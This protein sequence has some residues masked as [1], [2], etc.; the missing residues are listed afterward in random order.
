[1]TIRLGR[2]LEGTTPALAL[3]AAISA[4]LSDDARIHARRRGMFP[5]SVCA[6]AV[7]LVFLSPAKGLAQEP[8]C[9]PV[10]GSAASNPAPSVSMGCSILARN[11]LGAFSEP[12]VYW[13]VDRYPTFEDALHSLANR[14]TIAHV[15][16]EVLV[17][18]IEKE[19]WRPALPAQ[20]VNQVGPL[21][22][23]AGKPYTAV[24]TSSL[25]YGGQSSAVAAFNG[26]VAWL[27]SQSGMCIETGSGKMFLKQ[28]ESGVLR[29]PGTNLRIVTANDH[30]IASR[31][32]VA[33]HES[34]KPLVFEG[35]SWIPTGECRG[36]YAR[37]DFT[38]RNDLKDDKEFALWLDRLRGIA[39]TKTLSSLAEFTARGF[40]WDGV[41]D[42]DAKLP[43]L[44]N[45]SMALGG[46]DPG[47]SRKSRDTGRPWR[48]LQAMLAQ[49]S[50]VW[51]GGRSGVACGPADPTYARAKLKA[52]SEK[53]GS[54]AYPSN[55]VVVHQGPSND[56]KII[57][58]ISNVLV[59]VLQFPTKVVGR[60]RFA[61]IMMPDGQ[62]GYV[63]GDHVLWELQ[64]DK[65]CFRKERGEWRIAG[66]VSQ[67]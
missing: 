57:G 42:F 27:P 35:A 36:G 31:W 49:N 50:W 32:G 46:L 53:L 38:L 13:H 65:L 21:P 29:Q 16:D 9:I 59:Q 47:A 28:G 61:H 18:T 17:F 66:Y 45:F 48:Q 11:E 5:V 19:S 15:G 44:A 54:W 7:A 20:R 6:L 39:A 37:I 41:N 33:L 34:S 55:P 60:A 63:H 26:P 25:T 51:A 23:E 1:M 43:P 4:L 22:I 62:L 58:S 10:D 30:S 56:S 14:S 67:K 64:G 24:F 12:E 8:Q 2:V 3:S 52:V 40:F